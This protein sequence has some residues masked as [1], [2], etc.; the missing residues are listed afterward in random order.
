MSPKSVIYSSDFSIELQTKQISHYPL[1]SFTWISQINPLKLKCL[2]PNIAHPSPFNLFFICVRKIVLPRCPSWILDHHSRIFFS[3]FPYPVIIKSYRFYLLNSSWL[4]SFC[5]CYF[6]P[7]SS[8]QLQ[9]LP[10]L[11]KQPPF[12]FSHPLPQNT[13]FSH[14]ELHSIC[15]IWQTVSGLC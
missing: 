3:S 7:L 15:H 13:H 12:F 5:C 9:L 4:G 11:L 2:K 6:R 10:K 8:G 1:N 14:I